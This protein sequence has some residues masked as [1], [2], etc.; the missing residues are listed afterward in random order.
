[1]NPPARRLDRTLLVILIA[2]AALIVI[3]LI[4]VFTRGGPTALD[5]ATPEGVVQGYSTAVID[6]DHDAAFEYLAPELREECAG[7]DPVYT[8][9]MR[10]V[11]IEVTEHGDSAD[12]R[13]SLVTSYEGGLFG[14]SSSETQET[15][16]LVTSGGEWAIST[17]PWALAICPGSAGF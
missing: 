2:I 8:E 5:P 16:E 10:V 11:L 9:N 1:M 15:F 17:V 13:V 7:F 3:A 14:S 12:V 4:I 6:G